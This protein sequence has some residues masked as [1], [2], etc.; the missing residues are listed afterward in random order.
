MSNIDIKQAIK[1]LNEEINIR[2]TAYFKEMEEARLEDRLM[3]HSIL[4]KINYDKYNKIFNEYLKAELG[5]DVANIILKF[6]VDSS[7]GVIESLNWA[8]KL[9]ETINK[10][11]MQLDIDKP[12]LVII[13]DGFD[14]I[15]NRG[16]RFSE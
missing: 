7:W 3:D 10:I 1:D 15:K 11:I 6:T 9:V 16:A 14:H 8:E 4:P 12:P 5:N 2:A 13:D